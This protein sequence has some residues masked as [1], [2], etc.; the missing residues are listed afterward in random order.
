MAKQHKQ[1]VNLNPCSPSKMMTDDDIYKLI[2]V[3][4]AL[5][6]SGMVVAVACASLAGQ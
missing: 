4:M 1:S 6:T 5:M 2:L 3:V